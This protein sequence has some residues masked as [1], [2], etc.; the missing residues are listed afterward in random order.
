MANNFIQTSIVCKILNYS[1]IL[2]WIPCAA[3]INKDVPIAFREIWNNRRSSQQCFSYIAY[4]PNISLLF[5]SVTIK[6]KIVKY[7]QKNRE[8]STR[9]KKLHSWEERSTSLKFWCHFW[10][11][12]GIHRDQPAVGVPRELHRIHVPDRLFLSEVDHCRPVPPKIHLSGN[13]PV[14]RGDVAVAS[15]TKVTSTVQDR[16]QWLTAG[17]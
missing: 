6:H 8:Y 10:W 2:S 16:V 4:L 12:N 1:L 5:N 17:S 7:F 13:V 15:F 14:L 11:R 9:L 3:W